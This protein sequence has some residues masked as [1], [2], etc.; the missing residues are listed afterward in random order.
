M[1][2]GRAQNPAVGGTQSSDAGTARPSIAAGALVLLAALHVGALAWR[3]REFVVDDAYIGFVFLRNLLEG[4]GFVFHPGGPV[5]EGVTNIG[6]ILVLAPSAA[7]LDPVTAAKLTG[8]LLLFAC[9]L[10]AAAIGVKLQRQLTPLAHAETLVLAPPLLLAASFEFLYF[11]LAGME[12][13]ALACALLTMALIAMLKSDSLALPILGA[14]AFTFHPEALLVFPL[15]VVLRA[16]AAGFPHFSRLREKSRRWEPER[17]RELWAIARS[18]L[19]LILY[20]ALLALITFARWIHFGAVLPNTFASKPPAEIGT[21]INGLVE[22]ASGGH[23]GIGFPAAGLLGLGLILLGWLRL[24]RAS[25]SAAAM[26]GAVCATG[27][28]FALYARPDWTHSARYFAPYLP[29]ALILLWL[30]TIDL[31]GRLWPGRITPLAAFGGLVLAVLG[32]TLGA[33]LGAM[34]RYPGYVMASRTLIPPAEAIG[35]IVPEGDTIATRRIGALAYVTRRNLFDYVYGLTDP[36]VAR[37]VAKRGEAFEMP[38]VPELEPIWRARAP[39]WILED[40]GVLAEIARKAGGSLDYFE[41]YGIAYEA[42]ERFPI[43][44]EIDWVLA[45]RIDRSLAAGH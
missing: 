17:A 25:P 18:A 31:L 7:L 14:M 26:L 33:R 32:I 3:M 16:A 42:V 8:A 43:A 34:E 1:E 45:R 9:L 23:P 5:V 39:R 2:D 30:G 28:L 40:E 35:R 29:A 13:A 12:T 27:L 37:A 11:P 38:E 21:V 4:Q 44:P 41:V 10:L 22:L 15:F 24:H 6:W 36:E 20:I 19:P